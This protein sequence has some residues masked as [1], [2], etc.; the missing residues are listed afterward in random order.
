[1]AMGENFTTERIDTYIGYF[2]K[3]DALYYRW[4]D[5]GI[6]KTGGILEVTEPDY[7]EGVLTF[8]ED[9]LASSWYDPGYLA[10]MQDIDPEI[11]VTSE[12]I[13]KFTREETA[14]LLTFYIRG[15][16]FAPGT[17]VSA[18]QYGLFTALLY[19]MKR[20]IRLEKEGPSSSGEP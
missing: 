3:G 2:E 8:V 11:P 9:I 12:E 4:P 14:A 16:K 10:V 18:I 20:L 1:M 19:Q 17:W 13:R 15:E 5:S 6:V 7:E